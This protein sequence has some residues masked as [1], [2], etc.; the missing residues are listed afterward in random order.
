MH[1]RQ[2]ASGAA[3]VVDCALDRVAVKSPPA[4]GIDADRPPAVGATRSFQFR[5]DTPTTVK[6][7]AIAVGRH[8]VVW[9]DVDPAHR[10]E[11]DWRGPMGKI[12][13]VAKGTFDI[14]GKKQTFKRVG[15]VSGGTGITPMYYQDPQPAPGCK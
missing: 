6:A 12:H 7:E 3:P 5:G 1:P 13:Y 10:A 9:A 15:M 8:A 4:L 11:V 14:S 2:G